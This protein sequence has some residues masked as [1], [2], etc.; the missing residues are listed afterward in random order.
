[1]PEHSGQ[2]GPPG[3][4]RVPRPRLRNAFGSSSVLVM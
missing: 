3:R 2:I 4:L 1:L